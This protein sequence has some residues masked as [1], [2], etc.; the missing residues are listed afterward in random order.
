VLGALAGLLL[1][2]PPLPALATLAQRM[3]TGIDS[4]VLLAIPLFVL[5]GQLLN[6]GGAARGRAGR[7]RARV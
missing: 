7:G 1:A 4:F 6:H 2:V 5:S 3:A